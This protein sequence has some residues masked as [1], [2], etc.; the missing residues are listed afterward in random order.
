MNPYLI[1]DSP[2]DIETDGL[3]MASTIMTAHKLLLEDRSQ[4]AIELLGAATKCLSIAGFDT[5]PLDS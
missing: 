4:D 3:I 1:G 5:S 2:F